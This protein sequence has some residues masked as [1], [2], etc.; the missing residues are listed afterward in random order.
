LPRLNSRL[1]ENTMVTP[2][3]VRV[4]GALLVMHAAPSLL[5]SASAAKEAVS[6]AEARAQ[7]TRELSTNFRAVPLFDSG[8]KL[9]LIG[10]LATTPFWT[11]TLQL[12]DAQRDVLNTLDDLVR[13]AQHNS[14]RMD[15]DYMDQNPADYREH[16]SRSERRRL[17]S[18]AHAQ[19]IVQRGL[20]TEPQTEFV[21][22]RYLTTVSPKFPL[23]NLMVQS[24]LGITASQQHRLDEIGALASNVEGYDLAWSQLPE[25][26]NRAAID[27]QHDA[28]DAA[29]LNVLNSSQQT[30]WSELRAKRP[31]P[32]QPTNRL[33][34]SQ[35]LAANI[36]LADRSPT[37]RALNQQADNLQLTAEQRQLLKDLEQIAQLGL[38]WLD[39]ESHDG[40]HDAVDLRRAAFLTAVEQFAMDGI[41][42]QRQANQLK[43]HS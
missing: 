28:I 22:Q 21:I 34:L 23:R 13:H 30:R 6:A 10:D 35:E 31:S 5:V 20:L 17:N 11:E 29:V 14:F 9:H 39:L 26:A 18:L 41:L 16:V 33:P 7:A 15:A 40:H 38:H 2:T 12:A 1:Q 3:V 37:L 24:L 36:Q 32:T 42:T 4:L 8:C 25:H 19:R 27:N 43:S